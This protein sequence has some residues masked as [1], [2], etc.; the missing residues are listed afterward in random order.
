M[1]GRVILIVLLLCAAVVSAAPPNTLGYQGNL[2]NSGGQPITA[3]LGITF[4]L[5]DV[6]S[7]GSALWTETQAAVPV[8]GGNLSVELGAITPLPAL[9]WGKQLYLGIQIAG[10]SEMLPR[11]KLTAAPYALR[12]AGTM[13]NTFVVSGEGTATENGSTLLATFAAL[14]VATAAN[15]LTVEVDAGIFDLGNLRL[16][17]PQ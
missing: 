9:I 2:A 4:R 5:Y 10:D 6:A 16:N 8:D 7:G 15:P 14:P 12:A 13:K 1:S 11:P 3:S 17:M